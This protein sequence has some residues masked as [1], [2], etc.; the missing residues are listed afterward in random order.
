MQFYGVR[1]GLHGLYLRSQRRESG[2]SHT[3]II[4]I[5]PILFESRIG[6]EL[7]W[8]FQSIDYAI[9]HFNY[10]P[11]KLSMNKGEYIRC[12]E[13][14]TSLTSDKDKRKTALEQETALVTQ[15]T[16]A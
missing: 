16:W 3:L 2:L 6:I 9:S 11:M 15:P 12:Q 4:L 10:K 14:E 5:L 8:I 1:R 7:N 13:A